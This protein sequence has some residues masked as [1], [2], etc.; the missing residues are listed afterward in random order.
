M[1]EKKEAPAVVF[2]VDDDDAVRESLEFLRTNRLE[3]SRRT[4]RG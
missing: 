2:I 1:A 3:R 4:D